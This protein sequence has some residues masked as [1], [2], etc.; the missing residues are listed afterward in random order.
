MSARL[1][2]EWTDWEGKA[3]LKCGLYHPIGWRRRAGLSHR[4]S[5]RERGVREARA[6]RSCFLGARRSLLHHTMPC[7]AETSETVSLKEFFFLSQA[8]FVK[9]SVTEMKNEHVWMTNSYG[10]G[11]PPAVFIKFSLLIVT[12]QSFCSLWVFSALPWQ[13]WIISMQNYYLTTSFCSLQNKFVPF[14]L[15][16]F[17]YLL[18]F[19]NSVTPAAQLAFLGKPCSLF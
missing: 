4:R 13:H 17:S 18:A 14:H 6:L 15:L 19:C 12:P 7:Q 16:T 5:G 3:H 11:D 10:S 8:V 1:F 2:P 9:V